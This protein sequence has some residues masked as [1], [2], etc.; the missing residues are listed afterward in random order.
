[1]VDMLKEE[2]HKGFLE[3]EVVLLEVDQQ[4]PVAHMDWEATT[5]HQH[6]QGRLENHN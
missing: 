2:E 3:L 1:M 5:H 4:A 6:G